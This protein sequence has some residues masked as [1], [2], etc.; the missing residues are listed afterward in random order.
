[1]TIER[2]VA[3]TCRILVMES[4]STSRTR[5]TLLGRLRRDPTDQA[6]WGEFVERYSPQIYGWC[7]GWRLQDADAQDVTQEVLVI[8]A[9]RMATF[10]YDPA[11]SFRAWLKT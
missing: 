3:S 9:R 7:R 10:D 8:L 5:E 6:A 4:A 2:Q 1:M 11:R